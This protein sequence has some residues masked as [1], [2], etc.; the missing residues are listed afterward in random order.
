VGA[1]AFSLP[2]V[3]HAKQA[4]RVGIHLGGPL[5]I[6]FGILGGRWTWNPDFKQ[7][8]KDTWIRPSEEETPKTA[9]LIEGGCYW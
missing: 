3:V 2:L 5:Q 8:I 1:G 9:G 4:G 7:F 6:L